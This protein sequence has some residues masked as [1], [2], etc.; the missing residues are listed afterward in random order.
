[1]TEQTK[2]KRLAAILQHQLPSVECLEQAAAELIRLSAENETLRQQHLAA[3]NNSAALMGALTQVSLLTDLG[4]E[5]AEYAD[6]VE[7]VRW[8][9]A[10]NGELLEALRECLPYVRETLLNTGSTEAYYTE[11]K[12]SVAIK[13]AEGKV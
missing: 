4:G 11:T 9:H 6:V 13:K 5:V 12:A 2:A 3:H 8:L 10:L 1:M 7:A